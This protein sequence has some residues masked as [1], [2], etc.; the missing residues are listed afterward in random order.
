MKN[1]HILSLIISIIFAHTAIAQ[2]SPASRGAV[3]MIDDYYFE[4]FYNHYDYIQNTGIKMTYFV[5]YYPRDVYT[6]HTYI[7]ANIFDAD[8]HEIGFHGSFHINSAQY[9]TENT[10]PGYMNFEIFPGLMLM[11]SEGF[12]VTDFSY[13]YGSSTPNLKEYLFNYFYFQKLGSKRLFLYNFN[14]Q[15]E[16][17]SPVPLD[18]NYHVPDSLVFDYINQAFSLNKII[19]FYGHKLLD[20][21]VTFHRF[22]SV[23]DTLKA[24]Q[25]HFYRLDDLQDTALQK[26]L[27]KLPTLEAEKF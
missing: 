21:K 7:L 14:E 12:D 27:L 11:T 9:L 3:F 25:F 22:K 10:I 6:S 23:F 18:E 19:T 4:T 17:V 5:C 8:N 13:P 20:Q 26:S 2:N 16:I 1:R 24:K 15:R